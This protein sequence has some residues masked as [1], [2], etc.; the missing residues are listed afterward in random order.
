M[1]PTLSKHHQA[2]PSVR[3]L[4]LTA[5][6]MTFFAANSLLA[7]FALRAGKIDAG[8]FTAVRIG[9]G[10]AALLLL[11]TFR[12]D[13]I[14]DVGRHGSVRAAF[15]L[16]A[17]ALAFSFAYLSLSAGTGALVMF[18]AVQL[19]M[20]GMGIAAG[21]RL[22][23]LEWTG[24]A[25]AF[26]GLIYLV[27]PGLTAP[28]PIGVAL[29]TFSGA[30]WGY[31]SRAAKG[32]R[33]PIAATVGNFTRAAPLAAAA[34]LV[35]WALGQ[36][37][38]NWSG[39]A[40]AATSG[41]VTSGLGYAL[42]YVVMVDLPPSLAPIVQLTVPLIAAAAGVLLLGEHLTLRLIAASAAILGGVALALP[43]RAGV[44]KR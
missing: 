22:R 8:S 36:P 23:S 30:A 7:R 32:V 31:Y 19:T 29:M 40:L 17:Y 14:R 34:L 20:L 13:G 42:W 38:A 27:L 18:A 26:A 15:A 10:A 44:G 9:A 35:V 4:L 43:P 24:L 16:F 5:V 1:T 25:V 12:R 37:H 28:S 39:I 3:T 2:A 33:S 11:A 41:A 6:A 21:E